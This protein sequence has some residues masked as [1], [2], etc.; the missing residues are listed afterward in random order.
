MDYSP[1]ENLHETDKKF[2]HD[3]E[4][5]EEGNERSETAEGTEVAVKATSNKYS[6]RDEEDSALKKQR[7][8]AWNSAFGHLMEVH[9]S[10]DSSQSCMDDSNEKAEVMRKDEDAVG[11]VEGET[12][13][14]SFD[15][16]ESRGAPKPPL[17]D[18]ALQNDHQDSNPEAEPMGGDGPSSPIESDRIIQYGDQDENDPS[19]VLVDAVPVDE[20]EETEE[21]H[22]PA[23]LQ[24]TLV[25][26]PISEGS[27]TAGLFR[28][29]DDTKEA[30]DAPPTVPPT[31]ATSL[32]A[33]LLRDSVEDTTPWENTTTPQYKALDWLTNDDVWLARSMEDGN[34]NFP[35]RVLV[36][37]YALVVVSMAWG[38][39]WW[40][41]E[42]GMLDE[43]RSSCEWNIG[44]DCF[45]ED[46]VCVP[47]KGAMCDEDGFVITVAE[48][49]GEIPTEVGL[50]F[51]L[52][53]LLLDY[54]GLYG[55]IPSEL[56]Q[57]PNL[58][59]L[60][61]VGNSLSGSIP[62]QI[63]LAANLRK[64]NL[65]ANRIT[66]TLDNVVNPRL[67][68]LGLAQ[69]LLEGTI[70]QNFGTMTTLQ[71]LALEG[72]RFSGSI[73]GLA[74]SLQTLD[75]G[76]NR[77]TGTLD[78]VVHPLLETLYLS[79]NF[80]EGSIPQD[81][82]TMTKLAFCRLSDNKLSGSLP[83]T[84]GNLR[85]LKTLVLEGNLNLTGTVPATLSVLDLDTVDLSGTNLTNAQVFCSNFIAPDRVFV[86]CEQISEC[87]C[88]R[89]Y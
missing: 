22:M 43:K 15:R 86:D 56:V 88:C 63:G 61:L 8:D 38:D 24:E 17:S 46:D 83:P 75:L 39:R 29:D 57:L 66:G 23:M 78:N 33:D 84:L 13:Q 26:V 81:F 89:C 42:T 59:V 12:I 87:S 16:N 36:E 79:G 47:A 50:L 77:I 10:S 58:E 69:N 34:C 55:T 41:E 37:R 68:H 30:S 76:D 73:P 45:P 20:I 85:N 44:R 2:Q 64:L 4:E 6:K 48:A 19:S 80:L 7:T 35:I 18:L 1:S 5:D 9:Q 49:T 28:S 54:N 53:Y 3:D 14:G 82:G 71:T 62:S 25:A 65:H 31:T 11:N 51:S 60:D 21:H 52:E 72:N 74:A 70:P 27:L 67:E 32:L 40:S